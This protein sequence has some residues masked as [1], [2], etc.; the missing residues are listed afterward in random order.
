MLMVDQ[1]ELNKTWRQ[2][3]FVFGLIVKRLHQYDLTG[4]VEL[5]ADPV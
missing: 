3:I 1:I 4:K 2:V 5:K